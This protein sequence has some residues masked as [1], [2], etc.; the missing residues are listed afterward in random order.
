MLSRIALVARLVEPHHD[1]DNL[2]DPNQKSPLR[3]RM[4]CAGKIEKCQF[5]LVRTSLLQ[6]R[7]TPP[8]VPLIGDCGTPCFGKCGSTQFTQASAEWM[9]LV[10]LHV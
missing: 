8:L 2:G 9:V 1:H 3:R 4:A 7:H 5:R 6:S 10:A